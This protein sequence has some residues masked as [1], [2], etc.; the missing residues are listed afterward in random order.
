VRLRRKLSGIW[1]LAI[2]FGPRRPGGGESGSES[3]RPAKIL[4]LSNTEKTSRMDASASSSRTFEITEERTGE[5]QFLEGGQLWV[6]LVSI[7]QLE[8]RHKES[9]GSAKTTHQH[10]ANG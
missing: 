4:M 7:N 10:P 8:M 1:R 2:G 5:L 6:N 9:L 3:S